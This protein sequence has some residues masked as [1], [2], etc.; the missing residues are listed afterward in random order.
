MSGRFEDERF[1]DA[2]DALYTIV[3]DLDALAP[4]LTWDPSDYDDPGRCYRASI[5]LR[6]GRRVTAPGYGWMDAVRFLSVKIG[7]AMW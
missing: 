1:E 4:C 5:V 2:R 6:D 7:E 3:E